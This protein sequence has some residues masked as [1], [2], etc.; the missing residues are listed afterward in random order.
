MLYMYDYVVICVV[1][2]VECEEF[3]NVGVIVFCFG[4]C[5]L[6]VVIEIDFVC[7]WVFVLVFDQDVL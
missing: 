1:S 3:I 4:V 5:Y 7:L 6:E 2:W